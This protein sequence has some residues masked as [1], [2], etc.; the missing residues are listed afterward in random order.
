MKDPCKSEFEQLRNFEKTLSGIFP[1]PGEYSFDWVLA[2][3]ADWTVDSTL[4]MTWSTNWVQT[5]DMVG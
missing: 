2:V 4:L 5:D 3:H 1:R